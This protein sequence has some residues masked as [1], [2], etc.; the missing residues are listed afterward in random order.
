MTWDLTGFV[1]EDSCVVRQAH[2]PKLCLKTLRAF[3][4]SQEAR[5]P[6]MP[7][8]PPE[9]VSCLSLERP[10]SVCHVET[11]SQVPSRKCGGLW[12]FVPCVEWLRSSRLNLGEDLG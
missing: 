12:P 11:L 2:K 1:A 3:S 10:L 7:A 6:R 8:L 5:S 9:P 4:L